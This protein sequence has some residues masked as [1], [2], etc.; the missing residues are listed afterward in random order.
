M[1]DDVKVILKDVPYLDFDTEY[2]VVTT[3]AEFNEPPAMRA[4]L[5]QDS[6]GNLLIYPDA[7]GC[8]S[9]QKSQLFGNVAVWPD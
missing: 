2:S 7:G 3:A 8:L 6:G 9:A 5:L 1:D 4:T